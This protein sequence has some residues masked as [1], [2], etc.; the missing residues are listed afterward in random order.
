MLT[1]FVLFSD[2]VEEGCSF[3]STLQGQR[4]L[5]VNIMYELVVTSRHTDC[6]N[7]DHLV[8]DFLA[9]CLEKDF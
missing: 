4:M 5:K 2:T 9:S 3:L 7:S 6:A 1:H 8:V